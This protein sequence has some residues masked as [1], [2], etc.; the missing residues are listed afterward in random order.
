MVGSAATG[1]SNQIGQAQGT[2]ELTDDEKALIALMKA[3]CKPLTIPVNGDKWE[4]IS[5]TLDQTLSEPAVQGLILANSILMDA[6]AAVGQGT[7]A[8]DMTTPVRSTV[9]GQTL[10]SPGP[11]TR[12][13]GAPAA[14]EVIPYLLTVDALDAGYGL[15]VKD[16]YGT[17]TLKILSLSVNFHMAVLTYRDLKGNILANPYTVKLGKVSSG[18]QSALGPIKIFLAGIGAPALPSPTA[19]PR[20]AR[21]H[22]AKNVPAGVQVTK[23]ADGAAHVTLSYAQFYKLGAGGMQLYV[24]GVWQ[25]NFTLQFNPGIG[26][27]NGTIT[28]TS[29]PFYQG[30]AVI[31]NA[32]LLAPGSRALQVRAQLQGGQW[33]N[34]NY[35]LQ[36]DALP[37]SWFAVKTKGTRTLTWRP[38]EVGLFT[39][40]LQAGTDGQLLHSDPAK[41]DETGQLDNRTIPTS[42]ITQRAEANGWAPRS[43]AR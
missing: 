6:A 17:F 36:V 19:L 7:E 23:H 15:K 16:A 4:L 24:D 12:P 37:A 18:D 34:Y 38:G 39:P 28:W 13:A 21:Y 9:V 40:W 25:A 29:E 33:V 14:G 10:G 1:V 22:S 26:C 32:H 27:K 42:N 35:I 5:P 20:F 31:P 43:L 41:T 2:T 30:K 8:G 11:D 3:I